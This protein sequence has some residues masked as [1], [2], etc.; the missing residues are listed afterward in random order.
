MADENVTTTTTTTTTEPGLII[1]DL[2]EPAAV[3]LP[4]PIPEPVPGA[5]KA[6]HR[7]HDV[8]IG[9]AA[10][11]LRKGGAWAK[12]IP[13][14]TGI[15]LKVIP[16]SDAR[17]IATQ[18]QGHEEAKAFYGVEELDETNMEHVAM[19]GSRWISGAIVAARTED[20]IV[21]TPEMFQVA[22]DAGWKTETIED[23]PEDRELLKTLGEDP[24]PERIHLV[25]LTGKE[26]YVP[27]TEFFKLYL[28]IFWEKNVALTARIDAMFRLD[29]RQL[30]SLGKG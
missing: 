30:L 3:K 8:R 12:N 7:R 20:G 6:V 24:G 13:G 19:A 10:R 15:E 23:D 26:E 9:K 11:K 27:L 2:S 21:V 14:W 16:L 22:S 5:S 4:E 18:Q 1:T 28:A 17:V 25:H 29:D